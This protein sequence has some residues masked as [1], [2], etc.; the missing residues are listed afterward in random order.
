MTAGTD[1][2][3]FKFPVDLAREAD[4]RLG[5]SRVSPST[6]E[7]LRGAERETLEPRVM[8][9]LVALFQANGRVVSRDELISRCWEGRIVGEDAINRAI[10]RLRRLSEV[11]REASFVVETI[12]R[13]GYRLVASPSGIPQPL[14][15]G[16]G[17]P[18]PGAQ[19]EK[20]QIVPAESRQWLVLAV[21][22]LVGAVSVSSAAWL[23][24][25][26][27]PAGISVAVLPFDTLD[28]NDAARVFGKAVAEQI[29][30]TLNDLQVQAVSR[31]DAK[32][33]RGTDRDAAAAKL[34]VEFI[35]NGSVQGGDKGL[36][37]TVH[38]DHVLTHATVWTASYDQKGLAA[39]E[40]Q[41]QIAAVTAGVAADA[42]RARRED[43][44]E[45]DDAALGLLLKG[46][47]TPWTP[48]QASFLEKRD[49]VRA[50][51]ARA[52]KYSDGYVGLSQIS[53]ELMKTASPDEIPQLRA[54]A[55]KAASRGLALDPTNGEAYI[56]L[57]ML[58]P[59]GRWA[60]REAL[61]RR[62]IAVAPNDSGPQLY[63]ADELSAVGRL[64]E[65]LAFYTRAQALSPTLPPWKA[66]LA[67]AQ[68]ETGHVAEGLS[69]INRAAMIEPSNFVLWQARFYILANFG[70]VDEARA[71][72]DAT[73]NIPA[74]LESGSMARRA[75]LDA[76]KPAPP[77]AKAA[78]AKA[79]R[80]AMAAGDIDVNEGLQMIA[81][82]G[83]IDSAFTIAGTLLRPNDLRQGLT[84]TRRFLFRS[85]AAGMR[86]DPRFMPLAAKIGL[87]DTWEKTGKWPDFCSQPGLPYDCRTAARA[88]TPTAV[89]AHP[90]R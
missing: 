1:R 85:S 48:T 73:Q 20:V 84:M 68:V 28:S 14:V 15:S 34:G 63:L 38:L 79:I 43:P 9:V 24:W 86:R 52:P 81:K 65:A 33:L 10:G 12:P 13:V 74:S 76:L 72:L 89:V 23:L 31:E 83:D 54:E 8:Q 3:D 80:S 6:R 58:V 75:Y 90:G 55:A 71:M 82:L 22:V 51:I 60:E 50:L 39:S 46:H 7:V 70:H 53:S 49:L 88:L 56:A 78:A 64:R 69:L 29:V 67:L 77:A 11:D 36:H 4:F 5:A 32:T 27:R 41:S 62:G 57:A 2:P 40:F 66:N 44:A 87:V 19:N 16:L 42:I 45:M 35:V 18:P 21:L 59:N 47:T 17:A 26:A 25:P 61:Y 30:A 37:V